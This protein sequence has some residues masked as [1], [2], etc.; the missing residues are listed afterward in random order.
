MR[1]A[2]RFDGGFTEGRLAKGRREFLRILA[3]TFAFPALARIV[4]ASDSPP[5]PFS[6]VPSSSSRLTWT[7]TAGFS[8]EK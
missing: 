3:G 8:P 6:E 4:A 5:Y 2:P 1:F 7:H